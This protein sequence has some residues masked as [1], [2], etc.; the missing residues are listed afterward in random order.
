MKVKFFTL[1]KKWGK[2]VIQR[3]KNSKRSF[4]F[5]PVMKVP[6]KGM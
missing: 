3:D 2:D 4:D 5:N 1:Q 6:I